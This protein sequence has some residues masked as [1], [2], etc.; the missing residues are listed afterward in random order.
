MD[1]QEQKEEDPSTPA[2]QLEQELK[3]K[4]RRAFN[5]EV[6]KCPH[7]ERVELPSRKSSAE[8]T[9]AEWNSY[10]HILSHWNQDDE[11][12]QKQFRKD[13]HSGYALATKFEIK[14]I[15]LPSG[16]GAIQLQR[17]KSKKKSPGK[18]MVPYSKVFDAIY[19]SHQDKAHLRTAPTWSKVG[20]TYA[21]ITEK[22]VIAFIN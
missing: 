9:D 14:H 17:L 8:L 2:N 7:P 18:I 12:A 19:D 6:F 4:Q 3:E 11:A 20:E 15:T 21:N 16:V 1:S 22:Q 13:N 5:D 10:V